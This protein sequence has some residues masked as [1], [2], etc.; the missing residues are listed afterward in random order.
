MGRGNA[1]LCVLQARMLVAEH[2]LLSVILQT[3]LQACE[4]KK[5]K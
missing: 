5:S 1:V 3:F 4:E 2:D